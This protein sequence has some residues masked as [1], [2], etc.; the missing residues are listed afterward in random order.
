[1]K[2]LYVVGYF[3]RRSLY[4][5][6]H[7]LTCPLVH[8]QAFFAVASRQGPEFAS[9]G[10]FTS[11]LDLIIVILGEDKGEPVQFAEHDVQT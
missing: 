8:G 3:L 11:L 4:V 6:P 5:D 10:I 1:M 7:H 2:F 9:L